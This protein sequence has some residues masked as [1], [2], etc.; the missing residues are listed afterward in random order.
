MLYIYDSRFAINVVG[1]IM[2]MI[3]GDFETFFQD[4]IERHW[5]NEHE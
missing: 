3:K 2:V 1:M 4:Q 5:Q